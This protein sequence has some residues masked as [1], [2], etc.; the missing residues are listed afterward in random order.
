MAIHNR[1]TQLI[2]GIHPTK[3]RVTHSQPGQSSAAKCIPLTCNTFEITALITILRIDLMGVI[4]P[5]DIV[6]LNDD[7]IEV[8]KGF[9]DHV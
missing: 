9:G 6:L 4:L 2:A 1:E 5:R 7:A 3:T 8:N